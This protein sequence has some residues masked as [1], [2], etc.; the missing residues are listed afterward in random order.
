MI[1]ELEQAK[2]NREVARCLSP[3]PSFEFSCDLSF[4]AFGVWH[5]FATDFSYSTEF[6][7]RIEDFLKLALVDDPY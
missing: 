4:V 2:G 5:V 3:L 7:G 6:N 1:R